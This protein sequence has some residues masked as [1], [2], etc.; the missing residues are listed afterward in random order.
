MSSK[1]LEAATMTE[2]WEDGAG[3]FGRKYIEG[4]DSFEGF[5]STPQ[6]LS[7]R[8][9][10]EV[11]GII[12]LLSLEPGDS[13]L[14]CPCGYGRHSIALAKRGFHVLGSDINHEMLA[15]AHQNADGTGNLS[16]ACEN[17]LHLEYQ[18]SW[19]AVINM[20]LAFGFFEEES[21]NNQVLQNFHN[22]L[23]PG[24]RF[25][26]HTDVNVPRIVK[27]TYKLNEQRHLRS[28]RTLEIIESY[29]PERK[30]LN[31][32]WILIDSDGNRDGL[33]PYSCRIYTA[34]EI[35][36][37]CKATGFE[38]V[39]IFGGWNGEELSADSEE[40]IVVAHKKA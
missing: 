18:E 11:D 27:G 13:V 19:N 21:D 31:G 24:G 17:M 39:E 35:T 10:H 38:K 8:T 23:I 16:F 2:W 22:A 30:R 7:T 26:L 36:E 32:E 14:D 15:V 12:Q 25:L 6:T 34:P 3:F 40:M 9:Q 1:A 33:P 20:F 28:G 5:L 37:L 4:D 29:D